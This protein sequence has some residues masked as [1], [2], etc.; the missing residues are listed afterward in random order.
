[1]TTIANIED[2]S[3][4]RLVGPVLLFRAFSFSC[5]EFVSDL[6]ISALCF[7]SI[8]AKQTQFPKTKNEPNPLLQNGL[9]RLSRLQPAPK[10]TQSNPISNRRPR[11]AQMTMIMQNKAN[12][13]DA[14]INLSVVITKDYVNIRVRGP[15]QNK[16]NQTQFRT[17]CF[18][19]ITVQAFSLRTNFTPPF[20][21]SAHKHACVSSKLLKIP[22]E[23][24]NAGFFTLRP[25]SFN[26]ESWSLNEMIFVKES[27]YGLLQLPLALP[28]V[29][30]PFNAAPSGIRYLPCNWNRKKSA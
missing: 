26:T 29:I 21:V 16:P 27:S 30:S 5:F 23:Q 12:L 18:L 6:D 15:R 1:M 10:Q 13:L 9:W 17:H 28:G 24:K 20:S 4:S 2:R 7:L 11:T 19:R 14:K 25:L 8:Y 22:D 3:L